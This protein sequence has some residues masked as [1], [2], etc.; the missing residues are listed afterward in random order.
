MA[1]AGDEQYGRVTGWIFACVILIA[2]ALLVNWW[3]DIVPTRQRQAELLVAELREPGHPPRRIDRWLI[4][5]GLRQK[6]VRG[7]C[8]ISADL[9]RLGPDAVSEL[10]QVVKDNDVDLR[11][12]AADALDEIGPPAVP[13]LIQALKDGEEVLRE[14]AAEALGRIGPGAKHAVPALIQVLK[15]QDS[16]VRVAAAWALGRIG[17]AAKDALPALNELLKD[18][19]KDGRE[20]AEEALKKIQPSP[21]DPPGK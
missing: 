12:V 18:E 2:G 14:R 15:D 16:R 7:G 20:A 5:C 3:L 17:P 21:P 1:E 4:N 9:V 19:F 13:V 10:I 6:V 8:E 11:Y